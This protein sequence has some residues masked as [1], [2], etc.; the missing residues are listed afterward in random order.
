MIRRV[1]FQTVRPGWVDGE[2]EPG[3]HILQFQKATK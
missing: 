2:N 3:K 1:S